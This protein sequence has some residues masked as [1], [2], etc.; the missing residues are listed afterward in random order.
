MKKIYTISRGCHA[1]HNI[2]IEAESEDEAMKLA[3][4]A[5]D[6]HWDDCGGD[7]ECFYQV[8]DVRTVKPE[9]DE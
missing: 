9:N 3:K 8:E 1:V 4:E 7:D 6:E 2:D 5:P